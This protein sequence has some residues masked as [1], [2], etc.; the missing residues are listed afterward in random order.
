MD[1][2]WMQKVEQ[3]LENIEYI[4][5]QIYLKAYPDAGENEEKSEEEQKK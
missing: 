2:S 4:L 1:Y 3:K 5:S